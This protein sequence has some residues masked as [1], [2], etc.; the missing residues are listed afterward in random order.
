MLFQL[1]QFCTLYPPAP[2]PTTFPQTIPTPWSV[3]MGHA[4]MFFGCSIPY[5][6]FISPWLFCN[7]QF[8]P[9]NPFTF[10][11]HGPQLSSHLAT[12]KMFSMIL[13]LLYLFSYCVCKIQ[14]LIEMYLLPFNCSHFYL[15]FLRKVPLTFHKL[16]VWWW[17]IPLV[18]FLSGKLFIC[19]SILNNSFAGEGNLHCRSLLFI[20]LNIYCQSLLAYK[21]SFEKSA[22]GLL[23]MEV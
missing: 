8:V 12:I 9:L 15:L 11:T 18:F 3:S 1:S 22:D 20:T 10:F 14:L 21:I 2:R 4:Y 16:M 23:K 6:Y 5:V 13:F 19:P 7:Y 17:W